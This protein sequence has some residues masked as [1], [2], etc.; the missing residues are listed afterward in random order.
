MFEKP[1][2]LHDIYFPLFRKKISELSDEQLLRA[3]KE[4][5][6]SATYNIKKR[7]AVS[8]ETDKEERQAM[9]ENRFA[10]LNAVEHAIHERGL[11]EPPVIDEAKKQE[12]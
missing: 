2:N 9:V 10:M 5:R 3:L 6:I 4:C 8:S 11:E 12:K 7:D 1:E